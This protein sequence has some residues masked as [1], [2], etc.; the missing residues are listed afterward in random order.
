M[1]NLDEDSIINEQ[2]FRAVFENVSRSILL[3]VSSTIEVKQLK[4]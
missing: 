4:F 2:E 3:H 1:N